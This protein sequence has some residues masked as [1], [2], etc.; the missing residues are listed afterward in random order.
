MPVHPS[1]EVAPEGIT[2]KV[3]KDPS[4]I[5]SSTASAHPEHGNEHGQAREQDFQSKGPAIP[6][7]MDDLPPKESKD[8]LKKRAAELNKE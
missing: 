8:E 1:E 5:T 2:E 7:S 6:Q 3:A 4:S